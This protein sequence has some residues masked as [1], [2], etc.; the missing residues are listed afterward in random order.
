MAAGGGLE[1]WN[2][3]KATNTGSV[4]SSVRALDRGLLLMMG[5]VDKGADFSEVASCGARIKT[6]I[7]YGAAAGRID[8]DLRGSLR[9]Q[10]AAGLEE[11]FSVAVDEAEAGDAVLL[12]PGCASFD[13]F[14]DYAERGRRFEQ[15][16]RDWVA[17]IGR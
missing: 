14:A 13:E 2:D 8:E 17:G 16:A 15:L 4:V 10:L 3:S 6:V 12:A 9:V 1:F 7:A 5:G 11:A